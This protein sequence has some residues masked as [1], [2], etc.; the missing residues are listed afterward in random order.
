M[1]NRGAA[2][3]AR[4]PFACDARLKLCLA[5]AGWILVLAAPHPL[6]PLWIASCAWASLL[7]ARVS[8]GSV[9]RPLRAA[10]FTAFLAIVLRVLLTRGEP[11]VVL[12]AG[13]YSLALAGA[14]LREAARIGARILGAIAVA[15]WLSAITPWLELERAL[16][17]LRLPPP[18]LEI[19]SLT[20]R[21]VS[22]LREN[23]ETARGAQQLRLG[24][25]DL[26]SSLASAGVLA[27]L[28][29]GRALDQALVTGQAMQ[30]RGYQSER[31]PGPWRTPSHGNR[32]LAAL[33]LS[34]LGASLV[35][36][37]S[38]HW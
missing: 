37:G 29:L 27:G 20:Q 18:L 31:R 2:D 12:H 28:I 19:L 25:R 11:A 38:L 15:S 16:G 22:V 8:L 7:A 9:L 5:L 13:S 14:G 1:S 10:L 23:L 34:V 35:L 30:L 21:Y 17:W 3:A 26:R 6:I 32:R 36:S 24:Y 4:L 33:S